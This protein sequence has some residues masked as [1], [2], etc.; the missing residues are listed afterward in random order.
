MA[1]H[2]SEISNLLLKDLKK[3]KKILQ[4]VNLKSD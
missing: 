2:G 1:A 3:L 4:Y